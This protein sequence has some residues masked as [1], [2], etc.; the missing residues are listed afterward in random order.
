[1]KARDTFALDKA[2]LRQIGLVSDRTTLTM[3]GTVKMQ[4]H[5]KGKALIFEAPTVLEVA[6]LIKQ[7]TEEHA[8][9]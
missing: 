9:D 4:F 1:M 7:Y 3:E 8:D 2:M 5:H 6:F